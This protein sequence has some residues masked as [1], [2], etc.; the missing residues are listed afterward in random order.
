[1]FNDVLGNLVSKTKKSFGNSFLSSKQDEIFQ[2]L[3]I[4]DR[5]NQK[6]NTIKQ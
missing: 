4:L 5:W 3:N 6:K 1:M 2:R